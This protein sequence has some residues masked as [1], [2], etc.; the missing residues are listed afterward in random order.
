MSEPIVPRGTRDPI[1]IALGMAL[2]EVAERRAAERLERPPTMAV[3]GAH[4]PGFST[5]T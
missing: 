5:R 4:G 1:V 2:R 3:V